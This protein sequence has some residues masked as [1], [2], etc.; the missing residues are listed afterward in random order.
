MQY[1]MREN[2]ST[3]GGKQREKITP[4]IEDICFEG[5]NF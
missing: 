4:V 2:K 3:G 1:R 5:R